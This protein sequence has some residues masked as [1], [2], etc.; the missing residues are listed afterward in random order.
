METERLIVRKFSEND[1]S[2][3]HEYLSQ[4]QVLKY[5]PDGVSSEE[6][7]KYIA[8]ERAEG[9][10]FWAVS[11]KDT[12]K[13]IGHVYFG[14]K[15]PAEFNTWMI[16]YIF[17]PAFYG[18]GYATEACQGILKYGFEDLGIH[19]VMALC[20]PENA[21][22]WRLLERLNMRREGHFKKEAFFRRTD[23]GQP[24][25]HDAYQYAILNEEWKSTSSSK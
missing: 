8:R 24:L 21:P 1:W 5:E 9:D 16:G 2:D 23:D 13:M 25:W 6:D 19:R 22:S 15:E 17:N 18:K 11:L 7:C 3:L 20:S 12:N 10:C 14:Q 4:E